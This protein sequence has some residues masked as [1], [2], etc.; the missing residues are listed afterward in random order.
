MNNYKTITKN[1][2]KSSCQVKSWAETK[3][4]RNR[5]IETKVKKYISQKVFEKTKLENTTAL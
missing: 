5:H 2:K 1:K 3:K 4:C